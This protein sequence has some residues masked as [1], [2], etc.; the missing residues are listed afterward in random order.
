MSDAERSHD[1][2]RVAAR[3]DD[4]PEDAETGRGP[5]LRLCGGP[6]PHRQRRPGCGDSGG[7]E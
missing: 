6:P 5:D 1:R 2:H 7:G 4:A 3:E